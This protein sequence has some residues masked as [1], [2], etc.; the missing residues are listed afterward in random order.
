[1]KK[2][3]L[4]FLLVV[5][6]FKGTVVNVQAQAIVNDPLHMAS[7]LIGFVQ[8]LSEAVTTT[9]KIV[10]QIAF[11]DSMAKMAKKGIDFLQKVD[12]EIQVVTGIAD[13]SISFYNTTAAMERTLDKIK[14]GKQLTIPEMTEILNDYTNYLNATTNS[15]NG[16]TRLLKEEAIIANYYERQEMLKAQKA[17]MDRTQAKMLAGL[18]EA[19]AKTAHRAAMEKFYSLANIRATPSTVI[20][21]HLDP[22]QTQMSYAAATVLA[23]K[24]I[25]QVFGEDER[26]TE[27]EAKSMLKRQYPL[28]SDIFFSVCGIIALLSL[29]KLFVK[30]QL[31]EEIYKPLMALTGSVVLLL[32]LPEILGMI[33]L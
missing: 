9:S 5:C 11:A 30:I 18:G 19:E 23:M 6:S 28:Y 2:F 20:T 16:I 10:Q 4:F 29:F 7:N 31:G 13:L 8:G 17:E 27:T 25:E 26:Q 22:N 3:V 1:M 24:N 21:N 33:F 12:K 15:I 14:K 32:L